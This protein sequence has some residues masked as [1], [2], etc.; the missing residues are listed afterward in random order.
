MKFTDAAKAQWPAGKAPALPSAGKQEK[1][2]GDVL[3]KLDALEKT[4]S[5]STFVGGSALSQA[6]SETLES[7]KPIMSSIN[8]RSHPHV[9]SWFGFVMKFSDAARAQWPAEG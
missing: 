7:L 9:F 1:P 6:D 2:A 8:A 4:L 3:A 5:K